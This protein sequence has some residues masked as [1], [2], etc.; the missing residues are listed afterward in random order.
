[1]K[2]LVGEDKVRA[3]QQNKKKKLFKSRCD[4]QKIQMQNEE[5]VF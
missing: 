5:K 4:K 3:Q 2:Q 1:M